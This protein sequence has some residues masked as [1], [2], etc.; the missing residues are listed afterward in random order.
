MHSVVEFLRAFAPAVVKSFVWP[1]FWQSSLLIGFLFLLDLLLRRKLRPAVRYALWLVVLAKLVMPPSLALPTGFAWWVRSAPE[2]A[3][4][5]RVSSYTVTYG[6]A[7]TQTATPLNVSLQAAPPGPPSLPTS[8]WALLA[9]AAFSLLLLGFIVARW[10]QVARRAGRATEAAA[11]WQA[12]LGEA[13]RCAALPRSVRLKLT[14]EP[15]SPAVCGFFRPIILL[16]QAFAEKLTADQLR[17]VLLHELIHLRRGDVWVNCLQALLQIVYWWHPLLWLANA[18]IRRLR[19]EAVDDA[20][21]L[22]LREEAESYAPTLLEVAKLALRRPLTSLGLVGILESKT[23][24]RERIERLMNFQPPR[25]AGLTFASTFGLAAFAAAAIPMGEPP[26]ALNS[27]QPALATDDNPW[28]DPRFNGYAEIKLE[29]RFFIMDEPALR[30]LLP[31]LLDTQAPIILDPAQVAGLTTK[32]GQSYAQVFRGAG[33]L[34]FAKFSGGTFRWHVGRG[35]NNL[36][37]FHTRELAGRKVVVGADIELEA[38]EPDWVPLDFTIVPWSEND[39]L[40]CQLSLAWADNTNAPQ[41]LE[42]NLPGGGALAWARPGVISGRFQVAVLRQ[43]SLHA[44]G[45]LTSAAPTPAPASLTPPAQAAPHQD[46]GP[47]PLESK[48][49]AQ[50]KVQD[51]RLLYEM[52]KLDEAEA[53][54]REALAEEPQN[55]AAHYYL[56]L[57]TEAQRKSEP[58]RNPA[59]HPDGEPRRLTPLPYSSRGRSIIY[60]KLKRI[61]LET[62]S[63]DN[64]P[65]GQVVKELSQ[66]S[67]QYDPEKSGINFIINSNETK[68]PVIDPATGLPLS[69]AQPSAKDKLDQVRVT[70]LPA[71]TD[72]SLIDV[73]DAVVKVAQNARLK[74]AIE[75]YAVVFSLK[76]TN[77]APPLYVRIIKADPNTLR[78]ALLGTRHGGG[79]QAE[80]GPAPGVGVD[81]VYRDPWGGPY[82]ITPDLN[83]DG[84]DKTAALQAALRRLFADEG[85]DLK[86]PKS[87]FYNDREG[88]LMIRATLED[89]DRIESVIVKV[90]TS[91][92]SPGFPPVA[93]SPPQTNAVPQIRVLTNQVPVLGDLPIISNLFRLP[94]ESSL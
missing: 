59:P 84:R 44:N 45:P 40:R 74:Y 35:T 32:V 66:S 53:K 9:S 85:V 72:V 64:Q 10:R 76:G 30:S 19:E 20:V 82:V 89:L 15:M 4:R 43:P 46:A 50:S 83:G 23:A 33:P 52:G 63:F 29:P 2:P 16:P 24:L 11:P 61:R 69:S 65:L 60:S 93:P 42:L 6:P 27:V 34:D 8:A 51:A 58:G 71:I 87:I 90:N 7:A 48:L 54:L 37:N 13:R 17:V 31:A 70:I 88:S 78:D 22:A 62:L 28:P 68:S 12:L 49:R 47:S 92:T 14:A 75:D 5:P 81:G 79:T 41:Q 57:V 77:D 39:S 38:P 56:S 94:S 36:V 21:M 73:L 25:H 3:T 86:P 80:A 26:T 55:P 1:M 91:S 18:R 67:R